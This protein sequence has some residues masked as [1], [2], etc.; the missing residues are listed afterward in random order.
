MK[1]IKKLWMLVLLLA[2]PAAAFAS[3]GALHL[4]HAP[5]NLDDQASLQRGAKI[6]AA[7]CLACH[8]ASFMRYNRLRDL[9]MSEA[10]IR[11]DMLMPEET[12]IGST[13]Q[14]GM[15]ME[16]T[17][18]VYG[19]AAPDLSVIARSRSPDWIYT[20][21]RSFYVDSSRSSGWNN[22]LFPSVAMPHVLAE[23]QGEQALESAKLVLTKPGSLSVAEYDAYVGDLV[24]YLVYMSEPAVLVRH[25]IGYIVL[26]FLA[27]L[28]ILTYALKKE[29]WKDIRH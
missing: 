24:N 28:F 10:Q 29:I 18:T 25:K 4:N 26:G 27:V 17:R 2:V 15:N 8:G 19:V 22:E 14:A 7:N 1:A 5:V 11:Q 20:Y 3:G 13:M 6:F 16:A 21:M 12:K 23:F 9:G